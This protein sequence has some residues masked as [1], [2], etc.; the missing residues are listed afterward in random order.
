[1]LIKR[2]QSIQ[3]WK[4]ENAVY[5]I[6]VHVYA[7]GVPMMYYYRNLVHVGAAQ[8]PSAQLRY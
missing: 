4:Q 1:M 7:S 3:F 2:Y 5:K 8:K 6:V